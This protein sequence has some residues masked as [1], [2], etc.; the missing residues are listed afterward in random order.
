MLSL[1][2]LA[3]GGDDAPEMYQ[4]NK[5]DAESTDNRKDGG[6]YRPR[7]DASAEP[8]SNIDSNDGIV[9][10]EDSFTVD[11]S[12]DDLFNDA[13]GYC[14]AVYAND[15]VLAYQNHV[16][17]T[18]CRT[19]I[20]FLSFSSFG[21]I[22]KTETAVNKE[23][24]CSVAKEPAVVYAGDAWT[25]AWSDTRSSE[26]DSPEYEPN[27]YTL[28][29]GSQ[30]P[31]T[32]IAGDGLFEQ[33]AVLIQVNSTALLAWISERVSAGNE[34]KRSIRTRLLGAANSGEN[35]VVPEEDNR[36]PEGLV[37]APIGKTNAVIGWIDRS[38]ANTGVF[39]LPLDGDGSAKEA[40]YQL[41]AFDAT[42][43][44]IAAG[45]TAN[46]AVY[47]VNID[48]TRQVRLHLLSGIG[49][50]AEIKD[51]RKLVTPP[52]QGLDASIVYWGAN[53]FLVVYRSFRGSDTDS[54]MIRLLVIDLGI[55]WN[56]DELEPRDIAPAALGGGRTT[57]RLA[58]DGTLAVTWL[59]SVST[60]EKSLNL[61]RL[62]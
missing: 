45:D 55:D 42:S 54:A 17:A 10:T 27:L 18:D 14:L 35:I 37:A 24:F 39:V 61:R 36:M 26:T 51:E 22:P 34:R 2:S 60:E 4:P 59:D 12:G 19:R 13:R 49:G 53:G 40:P 62:H 3:C 1:F 50:Q 43:M 6:D 56:P 31:F 32:E 30:E 46:A 58:N 57:A 38:A 28:T 48:G 8:D 21:P 5:K 33:N 25:M 20:D 47:S 52:E 41:T 44:D 11:V 29:L 7:E 9:A 16:P 15:F 23:F